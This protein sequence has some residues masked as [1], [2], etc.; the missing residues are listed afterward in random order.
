LLKKKFGHI[1]RLSGYYLQLDDESMKLHMQKASNT[2]VDA[3]N[4]F[5]DVFKHRP[6]EVSNNG[7]IMGLLEAKYVYTTIILH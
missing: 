6:S 7:H 2:V 5:K 4:M 1:L 3:L